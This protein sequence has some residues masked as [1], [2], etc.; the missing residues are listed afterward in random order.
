M[1]VTSLLD[2]CRWRK[3][4]VS[5][6][7]MTIVFEPISECM[8]LGV[9]AAWSTSFL[10]RWDPIAVFLIHVLVWFIC[11]WVLIHIVQVYLWACTIP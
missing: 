3:L 7:P 9:L 6:T 4:H 1:T 10:F 11:D 5:S 2:F 8:L